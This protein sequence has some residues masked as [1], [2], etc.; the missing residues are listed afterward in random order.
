MTSS[1]YQLRGLGI[2][3]SVKMMYSEAIF[4]PKISN[5]LTRTLS[6]HDFI[7]RLKLGVSSRSLYQPC[8]QN[9]RFLCPT[10]SLLASQCGLKE[11]D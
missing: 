7:G 9:S 1:I 2:C 3:T 10:H 11:A 4:G 6:Q 8:S 5:T